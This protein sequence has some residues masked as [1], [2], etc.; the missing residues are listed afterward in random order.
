LTIPVFCLIPVI[1]VILVFGIRSFAAIIGLV[2]ARWW[3]WSFC[4][5]FRIVS[6]RCQRTGVPPVVAIWQVVSM[7]RRR[8]GGYIIHLGVVMMSLG[9][10]G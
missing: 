9:V 6:A 2:F 5:N 10:I 7:N 1:V 8:Y 4:T 3:F